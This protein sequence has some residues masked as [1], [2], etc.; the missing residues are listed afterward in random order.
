MNRSAI[1]LA[2][3][4]GVVIAVLLFVLQF[5]RMPWVPPRPFEAP[6]AM[7]LLIFLAAGIGIGAR[8]HARRVRDASPPEGPPALPADIESPLTPREHEVLLRLSEGCSNADIARRHFVSENTVKSQV[9]QICAKLDARS[10]LEA[11]ARARSLGLL[12]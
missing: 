5:T 2:L 3:G 8:M 10:R 12:P 6:L 1:G 11:V 7:V 9:R 4:F